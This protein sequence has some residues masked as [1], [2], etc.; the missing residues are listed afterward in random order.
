VVAQRLVRRICEHCTEDQQPEAQDM[1]LLEAILGAERLAG[2]QFKKGH[3]CQK[4]NQTGYSG[5][6][7]V[8]ELLEINESM[9]DA[10]RRNDSSGF[11]KAAMA[12][13][14]F[15]PLTY[16]ALDY[17][18]QGVTTLE[19]VFRVSE[20]IDE[21]VDETVELVSDEATDNN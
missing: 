8:F 15:K 4:C 20:Q 19:E 2:I 12:S 3:G 10:L 17:A 14:D 16:V 7:G 13:P 5:R 18:A 21:T 9:A 1:I 11:T 6:V